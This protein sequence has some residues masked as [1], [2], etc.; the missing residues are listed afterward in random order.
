ML[1]VPPLELFTNDYSQTLGYFETNVPLETTYE[2]ETILSYEENETYGIDDIVRSNQYLYR[3]LIDNNIHAPSKGKTT[4]Y[5]KCISLENRV[6]MFDFTKDNVTTNE[7]S[8]IVT[9]KL[10]DEIDVVALFGLSAKMVK[11]ELLDTGKNSVWESSKETS[12]RNVTDWVSWTS[13]DLEYD[14][15]VIFNNLPVLMSE[16]V[17][18]TI[19]NENNTAQC[20]FCVVGQSVDLGVTLSS[21][22]PVSSVKNI[23]SKS[24]EADGTISTTSSL[25]YKRM[26]INIVLSSNRADEVQNLLEKYNGTPALFLADERAD[27]F[28]SLHIFGLHKDFDLP[29]GVDK[30]KYQLEIE[31][32][33]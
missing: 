22:E 2:N 10:I 24:H 5:W 31:G 32:V 20:S 16:Y 30:S 25:T 29:I 15:S 6:K 19:T 26:N 9:L 1:I 13:S 33:V 28:H 4:L 14:T 21:P 12:Y 27:G 18:I 7:D 23:I 17:R 3:S 8:I 11:I